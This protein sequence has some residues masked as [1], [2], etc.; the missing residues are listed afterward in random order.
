M[1]LCLR[2]KSA[3]NLPRKNPLDT[4]DPYV[5]V[6]LN[7]KLNVIQTRVI[8]NNVNPFWNQ[9]LTIP[10]KR[11]ENVKTLRFRVRN[12]DVFGE[13]LDIGDCELN[14][15]NLN[16]YEVIEKSLMLNLTQDINTKSII[17][18]D[19]QYVPFIHDPFKP[20]DAP[21]QVR[22]TIKI[23][24]MREVNTEPMFFDMFQ[25]RNFEDEDED[26]D[27][28]DVTYL[29]SRHGADGGDGHPI[30]PT[31]SGPNNYVH[32]ITL[33]DLIRNAFLRQQSRSTDNGTHSVNNSNGLQIQYGPFGRIRG[34]TENPFGNT[35]NAHGDM[36][37]QPWN[38]APRPPPPNRFFGVRGS[39]NNRN[40][41]FRANRQAD[42]RNQF[43]FGGQ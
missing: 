30:H 12:H 1:K 6:D 9:I 5:V 11:N 41:G 17:N 21:P 40:N 28:S 33:E 42:D 3:S 13:D 19:L 22:E 37:N 18:I 35:V 8:D 20:K 31:I 4:I 23:T 25:Q 32:Q 34:G 14:V 43:I 38:N 26:E 36:A 15:E 39:P 7:S 29:F 16:L 24:L 10:L 27:S 2:I